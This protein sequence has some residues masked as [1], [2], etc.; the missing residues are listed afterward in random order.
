[1]RYAMRHPHFVGEVLTVDN[2][3]DVERWTE[4]KLCGVKLLP[5]DRV[6]QVRGLDDEAPESLAHVGDLILRVSWHDG[7]FRY[8][9][10][11]KTEIDALVRPMTE[12][13]RA[14]NGELG[15]RE[16]VVTHAKRWGWPLSVFEGLDAEKRTELDLHAEE[17]RKAADFCG[18]TRGAVPVDLRML[19][20]LYE[21][22]LRLRLEARDLRRRMNVAEKSVEEG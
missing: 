10:V 20:M 17:L 9:V 1:M 7:K 15:A 19:I 8:L 13:E 21:E 14:A 4:G 5:E 11:P 12:A 6:L 18:T 16:T 2:Q 22:T 3:A